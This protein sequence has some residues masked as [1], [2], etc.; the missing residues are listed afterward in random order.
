M[1]PI[2]IIAQLILHNQRNTPKHAANRQW[3]GQ[4]KHSL[5]FGLLSISVGLGATNLVG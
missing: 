1:D 5:T 3:S 4:L 2:I